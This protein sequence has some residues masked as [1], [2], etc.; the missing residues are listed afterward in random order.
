MDLEAKASLPS[1]ACRGRST[2]PA[3][4]ALPPKKKN[5]YRKRIKAPPA[6]L[7]TTKTAKDL[8]VVLRDLEDTV[9]RSKG[10]ENNAL[11]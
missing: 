7:K 2:W 6:L 3:G 11:Q 1:T 9:A 5:T 8:T 10:Q 4:T